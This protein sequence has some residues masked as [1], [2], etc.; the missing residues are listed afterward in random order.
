MCLR[1]SSPAGSM[2]V[3]GIFGIQL[4]VCSRIGSPLLPEFCARSSHH[5]LWLLALPERKETYRCTNIQM[6]KNTQHEQI[7]ILAYRLWEKRGGPLGSPDDD[8]F[9]AEREL[10]Q[11]LNSPSRPPISSLIVEPLDE[12]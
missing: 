3:H 7:E 6:H 1:M 8:W 10:I 12:Y 5:A 4:R 11:R 2:R 9:R